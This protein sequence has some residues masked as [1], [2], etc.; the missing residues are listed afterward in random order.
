MGKNSKFAYA[1]KRND[2]LK[3]LYG[4][5]EEAYQVLLEAQ[6]YVCKICGAPYG[7]KKRANLCV[8]HDHQTGRIRGLLCESC[9][10]MLGFSND[11]PT[12]LLRAIQYLKGNLK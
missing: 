1:G 8:D 6:H 7:S 10:K 3:R 12:L 5:T 2:N 9:N 11:N 4:I